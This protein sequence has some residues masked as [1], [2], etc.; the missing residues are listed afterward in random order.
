MADKTSK[1]GNPKIAELV[2]AISEKRR[3]L[4]LLEWGQVSIHEVIDRLKKQPEGKDP[5]D[6]QRNTNGSDA[7]KRP[8]STT[9]KQD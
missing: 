1:E 4:G 3:E 2:A 7:K 9:G 6:S 8:D 5:A